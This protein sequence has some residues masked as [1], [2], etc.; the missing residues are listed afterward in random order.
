MS[1]LLASGHHNAQEHYEKCSF[2]P[3]RLVRIG[4]GQGPTVPLLSSRL[5][6]QGGG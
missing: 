2:E 4:S 6:L 3:Q 1:E 5:N